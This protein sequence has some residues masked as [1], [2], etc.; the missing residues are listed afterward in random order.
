MNKIP[1]FQSV[2]V[3]VQFRLD[4]LEETFSMGDAQKISENVHKSLKDV[5][6][7][8]KGYGLRLALNNKASETRG[9]NS[10]NNDRFTAKNGFVS[11]TG[12]GNTSRQMVSSFQPL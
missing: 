12:I 11:G 8:L 3:F 7:E 6:E 10:N 2:E 1:E 4:D 9:F 5:M